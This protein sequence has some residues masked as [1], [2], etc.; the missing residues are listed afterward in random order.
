VT[1][2]RRTRHVVCPVAE[3]PPGRTR[4]FTHENRRIVVAALPGQEYRALSDHC[5]HHGGSLAAGSLERMWQADPCGRHV[6][7]ENRWVVVC[8]FHN[9]EIDV[10]TG[11]PVVK[12]GRRTRAATYEVTV[13]EGFVVLYV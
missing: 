8:P 1:T 12:L 11:R 3:L 7:D 5:P 10:R 4:L 13:E 2:A 9:Y 6:P